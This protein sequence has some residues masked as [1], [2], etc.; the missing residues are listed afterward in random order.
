MELWQGRCSKIEIDSLNMRIGNHF[1][2]PTKE[3]KFI[4]DEETGCYNCISH[5]LDQGY[6]IITRNDK[7]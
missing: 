3:I 4:V 7:K 2:H 1:N 5:A 6:P